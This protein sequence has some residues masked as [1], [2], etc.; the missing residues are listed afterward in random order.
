L[1]KSCRET[2]AVTQLMALVKVS[3][4]CGSTAFVVPCT[5]SCQLGTVRCGRWSSEIQLRERRRDIEKL[6]RQTMPTNPRRS[7]PQAFRLYRISTSMTAEIA[8]PSQSCPCISRMP[9]APEWTVQG[10]A[11]ARRRS[12]AAKAR[13]DPIHNSRHAPMRRK[14]C[15]YGPSPG[16]RRSRPGIHRFDHTPPPDAAFIG[17]NGHRHH[18]VERSRQGVK[19]TEGGV[20]DWPVGSMRTIVIAPTDVAAGRCRDHRASRKPLERS[21]G[22]RDPHEQRRA[23]RPPVPPDAL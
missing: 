10:R 3:G 6:G 11:A 16:P 14:K 21:T 8:T 1:G 12:S 17:C 23:R 22:R 5:I 7:A 15:S 2:A 9:S 4:I 20:R 13:R 19:Q 18:A